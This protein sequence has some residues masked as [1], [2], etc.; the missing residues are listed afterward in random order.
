MPRV[1]TPDD[2]ARFYLFR[3]TRKKIAEAAGLPRQILYDRIKKPG[4]LKLDELSAICKY[5][6]LTD[7]EI[8]R[9]I[10]GRL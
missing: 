7:A 5:Q 6:D 1:R 8:I 9:I 3:G 4:Q 2:T 10:R